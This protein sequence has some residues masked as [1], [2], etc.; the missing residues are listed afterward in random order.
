[1]KLPAFGRFV[2]VGT[3]NTLLVWTVYWLT[4]PS[5]GYRLAFLLSFVVGVLFSAAGHSRLSFGLR[6]SRTGLLAYSMYCV[7]FYFFCA[8]VLEALIKGLD[9]PTS[10]GWS[11]SSACQLTSSV[12]AG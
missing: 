3:A 7:G 11:H 2:V 10:W 1:V 4:L 6:L 9:V 12:P 5:L 8:A